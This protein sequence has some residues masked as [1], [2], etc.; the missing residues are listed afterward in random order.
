MIIMSHKL[1]EWNGA[2]GTSSTE[3]LGIDRNK[4]LRDSEDADQLKKDFYIRKTRQNTCLVAAVLITVLSAIACLILVIFLVREVK[5]N[6]R[7]NMEP[8]KAPGGSMSLDQHCYTSD[9]LQVA[10]SLKRNMNS[11]VD[12]CENFYEHS[13]ASW[14]RLNPIPPSKI[15]YDT[16]IQADDENARKLREFM[17]EVDELPEQSAVKKTKRYFH[18]CVDEEAVEQATNT[19]LTPH[20]SNYGSW[21]LDKKTWNA[22]QWEWS[23]VLQTMI[24]DLTD[25]PLFSV[26]IDIDP[27]NSSQ[28]MILVSDFHNSK[29]ITSELGLINIVLLL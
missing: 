1:N 6:H 28:H 18:S 29:E 7:S 9:C 21:P 10:A 4:N 15:L 12:P 14:I 19:S 5:K 13:C 26:E 25:T 11:S 20:I 22:S 2:A 8:T 3:A 16:F 27:Q 23:K 24:R 17:E